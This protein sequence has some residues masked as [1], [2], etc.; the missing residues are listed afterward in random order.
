MGMQT[1]RPAHVSALS[2]LQVQKQKPKTKVAQ[3]EAAEVTAEIA[4]NSLHPQPQGTDGTGR[5]SCT[6]SD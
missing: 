1:S 6:D 2:P 5:K 3:A 4:P